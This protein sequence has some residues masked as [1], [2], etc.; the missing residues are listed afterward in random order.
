MLMNYKMLSWIT[1]YSIQAHYCSCS[2]SFIIL[3]IFMPNTCDYCITVIRVFNS[4]HCWIVYR[5]KDSYS[6]FLCWQFCNN[7]LRVKKHGIKMCIQKKS[8]HALVPSSTSGNIR[9]VWFPSSINKH[10]THD[11][12]ALSIL[13]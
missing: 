7:I 5:P 4:C 9:F 2:I 10:A 12:I 3:A 8:I 6:T 11:F 13:G 1:P